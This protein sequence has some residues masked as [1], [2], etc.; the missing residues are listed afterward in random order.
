MSDRRLRTSKRRSWGKVDAKILPAEN[1]QAWLDKLA[2][3]GEV[4]VP[5]ERD[6]ISFFERLDTVVTPALQVR[7]DIPPK[8]LVFK[9]V[10]KILSYDMGENGL[11]IEQACKEQRYKAIF[12]IRPCDAKA[13]DIID[14]VFLDPFAP[15]CSYAAERERTALI[16]LGCNKAG[17]TCFCTS[18]GGSPADKV[19]DVWMMDL[20]DHFFV[21]VFS[22]I[23]IKLVEVGEGLFKDAAPG[24]DLLVKEIAGKVTESM[25]NLAIPS[26]A[27]LD[28]L[29]QDEE[30]WKVLADKCL[31]CGTCT[32][33]CPTCHCY[34]VQD[35]GSTKSGDRYRMWDSC[36]FSRFTRAAGGHNPRTEH[37]KRLRQR[38]M[39]KFSYF[40]TNSNVIGCV[41][42]GR[43][44]RSCPVAFDVREFLNKASMATEG[45][46]VGFVDELPSEDEKARSCDV[47]L[48][49]NSPETG[50]ISD[51][52]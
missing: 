6:G 25:S 43:C 15:E 29:F 46:P 51:D 49:G 52:R 38:M 22:P 26:A 28:K 41:G 45:M 12:G 1:L 19:G 35:E 39:H 21:E 16:T 32:F 33:L 14:T 20:G 18:V 47:N 8:G 5:V 40:V 11:R 2:S 7:T 9:R 4:F 23:G 3:S 50:V 13:F 42:C 48:A 44:I 37:W 17:R 30:F 27:S 10:E 34:D 31:S 24:D 36:M